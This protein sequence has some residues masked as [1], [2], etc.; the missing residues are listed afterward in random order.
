MAPKRK[1][2]QGG[3]SGG[4]KTKQKQIPDTKMGEPKI[5]RK[6]EELLPV[7]FVLY[8]VY[9]DQNGCNQ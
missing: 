6:G 1:F 2:E 8:L 9:V 3:S 7:R 4:S 5:I